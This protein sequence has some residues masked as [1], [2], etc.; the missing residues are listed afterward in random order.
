LV[1]VSNSVMM[2]ETAENNWA[3]NDLMTKNLMNEKTK[4]LNNLASYL[5]QS[6]FL[7]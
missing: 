3:M 7:D 6:L 4:A 1:V 5:F 2:T